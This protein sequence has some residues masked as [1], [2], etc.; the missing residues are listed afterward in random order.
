MLYTIV[1]KET[2]RRIVM[3]SK[4][5]YSKDFILIA[6]GQLISIFGNQ[7]VRYALPLYILNETGSSTLF[8]T[9]LALSFV[10]MLLLLPIGGIIVDRVNKKNVMVVLDFLTSVL[11]LFF[12]L[13]QGKYDVTVLVSS[14]MMILFG[15]QGVYGPA[16]KASIPLIVNQDHILKANSIID[17][18]DSSASMLGP[19][20]GGLL[21]S[22]IGL[23]PILY[24]SIIAFLLSAIMEFFIYIPLNKIEANGNIIQTGFND[25]KE[26]FIFIFREETMLWK[27][28]MIY[29]FN[30]ILL[31]ALILVGL[32][33]LITQYLGFNI[34]VA[35]RLYGYSQGVLAFGAIMGGVLMGSL[36][37]K[38]KPTFIPVFLTGSGLSAIL[39]GF[40]LQYLKN[41]IPIYIIIL[42]GSGLLMILSTL[43]Q[44][45]IMS[46]LQVLTP[47]RLIGKVIS[48]VMYISMG[49]IPIGQF[50]YGVIF[51][52]I[53]NNI[54]IP[55]YVAGLLIIGISITTKSVFNKLE[56]I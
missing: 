23:K 14:T 49:T 52:K 13:L 8:G 42:I 9:V 41:A 51:D 54:Y 3:K 15:I 24:I 29:A 56:K 35:N 16:V 25:L 6:I 45:Q 20:V 2:K 38:I 47:K 50:I 10:P 33:V 11:I 30:N 43:F 48:G 28:S 7:I 55:F 44:I 21:F 18:V 32:P 12:I 4:S 17:L 31:N 26:S 22:T 27:L 34:N 46:Y 39:I 40:A 19:V 1:S 53:E 36:S 5:I 37:H